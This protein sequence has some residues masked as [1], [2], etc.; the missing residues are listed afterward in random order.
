MEFD[1]LFVDRF[2]STNHNGLAQ[3]CFVAWIESSEI[4]DKQTDAIATITPVTVCIALTVHFTMKHGLK[5][6]LTLKSMAEQLEHLGRLAIKP[7][8]G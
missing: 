7:G 3:A 4:R 2:W 5:E 8:F 6:H 1:R